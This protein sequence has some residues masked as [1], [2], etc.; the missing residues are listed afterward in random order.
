MRIY[1]WAS[2][3]KLL[4]L[5]VA[6]SH[7]TAKAEDP[8]DFKSWA[9][10]RCVKAN[11]P[12]DVIFEKLDGSEA[13]YAKFDWQQAACSADFEASGGQPTGVITYYIALRRSEFMKTAQAARQ[14]PISVSLSVHVYKLYF[15][16]LDGRWSV[17]AYRPVAN[18]LT[19]AL[20]EYMAPSNGQVFYK[21]D[22]ASRRGI[23]EVPVAAM[24]PILDVAANKGCVARDVICAPSPTKAGS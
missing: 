1:R 9:V 10:E 20:M 21:D 23:W 19:T 22:F 3:A 2:A 6:A 8:S 24:A 14:S 18:T 16:R 5:V 15:R 13:P 12:G 7:G 4:G 17:V 11:K